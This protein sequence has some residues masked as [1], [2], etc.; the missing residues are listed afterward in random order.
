MQI[1]DQFV[2]RNILERE[3]LFEFIVHLAADFD[4]RV[5]QE[6]D[7]IAGLSRLELQVA[8]RREMDPI[9]RQIAEVVLLHL[10][11]LVGFGDIDRHPGV[12]GDEPAP[13]MI[14]LDGAFF[15][16]RRQ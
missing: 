6:V 16:V 15:G 10:R 12:V 2:S 8:T 14:T 13:A 3:S 4:V 11:V 9:G 1:Q 7:W 5:D